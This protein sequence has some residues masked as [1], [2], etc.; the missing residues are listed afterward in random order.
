MPG[1]IFPRCLIV[2]R[3]SPACCAVVD[4][5]GCGLLRPRGWS[6]PGPAF[7]ARFV[8][9]RG[10]AGQRSRP[11]RDLTCPKARP[12]AAA[13]PRGRAAVRRGA[14]LGI[15]R[16]SRILRIASGFVIAGLPLPDPPG[17]S[18]SV[19][20]SFCKARSSRGSGARTRPRSRGC[21][22]LLLVAWRAPA[23]VLGNEAILVAS[24]TQHSRQSRAWSVKELGF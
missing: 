13:Q 1:R 5:V 3:R 8:T 22:G 23:E 19:P 9:T 17:T 20:V 4:P 21:D 18:T 7:G 12:A 11:R 6:I 2:L 14:S 16:C 24:K 15:P 10:W